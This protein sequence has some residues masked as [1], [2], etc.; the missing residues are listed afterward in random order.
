LHDSVQD[1][2]AFPQPPVAALAASVRAT[3]FAAW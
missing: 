2:H 3:A 1:A